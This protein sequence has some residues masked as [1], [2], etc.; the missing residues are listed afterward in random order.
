VH[1]AASGIGRCVLVIKDS[2]HQSYRLE[3]LDRA[4]PMPIRVFPLHS[5]PHAIALSQND[6]LIAT[7]YSRCVDIYDVATGGH[8]RHAL[9]SIKSRVSPGNHVV[10]FSPDSL[11]VSASTRYE[12]EKVITYWSPCFEPAKAVSCETANPTGF[13]GDNG[14]SAVLCSP[15]FPHMSGAAAFVASFTEKGAPLV[16]NL[17]LASSRSAG[18]R[19]RPIHDPKGRVGTRIHCAA[20]S[21]SGNAIAL[22][23]QRNDV[24]FID[25]CWTGASE[26][27]RVATVKRNVSV[28]KEVAVGMPS[29]DE[30]NLFWLEKGK[31]VL[32]TVGKGGG[33]SKPI[34]LDVVSD[35]AN[36]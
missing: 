5:P 19:V 22:V 28:V 26:P 33:K 24:F 16:C 9:P 17:S 29:N 20:L 13:P 23:N 18:S 8:I 25:S 1:I 27:K 11:A 30:A 36:G 32:V 2:Q 35:L 7:K 12:P 4:N 10:C 3:V 14:L 34:S 15:P 6:N 21:P 31:G